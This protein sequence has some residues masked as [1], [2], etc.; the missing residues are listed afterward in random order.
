MKHRLEAPEKSFEYFSVAYLEGPAFCQRAEARN[1]T[2]G[3]EGT[4]LKTHTILAFKE[5]GLRGPRKLVPNRRKR[6]NE[7]VRASR[8]SLVAI[9]TSLKQFQMLL[10]LVVHYTINPKH[11]RSSSLRFCA[12]ARLYFVV[13]FFIQKVFSLV[14][15]PRHSPLGGELLWCTCSSFFCLEASI[16]LAAATKKYVRCSDA[17]SYYSI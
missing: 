13:F 1:G 5:S 15:P 17:F 8:A 2:R 6:D 11:V 14:S 3:P 9:R 12:R 7:L 4:S 10:H 16:K